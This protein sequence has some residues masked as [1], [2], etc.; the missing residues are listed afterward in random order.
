MTESEVR[1]NADYMEQHLKAY[2]Y[3]YIVADI[4]WY[5]KWYDNSHAYNLR[6]AI[7]NVDTYGR[8]LPDEGRSLMLICC[9][10]G[11]SAFVRK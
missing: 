6:D 7:Y 9:L 1:A 4:R 11:T 8:L 3:E 5:D 2:G 10:W